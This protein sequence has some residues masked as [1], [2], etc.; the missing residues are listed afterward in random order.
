M[1]ATAFLNHDGRRA[2]EAAIAEAEKRT[3]AEIVCAVAAESGRYDRA[4]SLVGL[5]CAIVGLSLAHAWA[6][7]AAQWGAAPVP[8]GWQALAVALGFVLGS[9]V[10]SYVHGLR[11]LFVSAREMAEETGRAA[12]AVFAQRR[13][14]STRQQAGLLLYVSLFERRAVVLADDGARAA[15]GQA[16]VD[17]LRDQM[18]AGLR[19]GRRAETLTAAVR[20]AAERLSPRLPPV[21]KNPNE[22]P[23]QVLL[24]D[25][26]P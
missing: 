20:S 17:A 9:V 2:V 18:V 5:G 1:R 26:R 15:L 10:A 11:R 6:G 16:G 7:G 23:N 3:A 21:P 14:G 4:E 13:L 12:S 24:F 8:L 22:L 19:E 25:P